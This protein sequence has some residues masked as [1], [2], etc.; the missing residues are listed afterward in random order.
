M[1]RNVGREMESGQPQGD[2]GA[3]DEADRGLSVPWWKVAVVLLLGGAV[4]TTLALKGNG[5]TSGQKDRDGNKA[6]TAAVAPGQAQ[7]RQKENDRGASETGDA[8][9]KVNG[10]PITRK[11]FQSMLQGLP[12][13]YR[14]GGTELKEKL[15]DTMIERE[16]LLQEADEQGIKK[17]RVRGG[18]TCCGPSPE[19]KRDTARIESLIQQE[20]LPDVE[21]TEEEVRT[22][23]RENKD[24]FGEDRGFEEIKSRLERKVRWRKEKE[25][26]DQYVSKLKNKATVERAE[27]PFGAKDKGSSPQNPLD[28]ALQKDVPV[29]ADFGR[30]KCTPC[31][32]MKP[33]LE[34]LKA[35]YEGRAE[36]LIIDTGDYPDLARRCDVRAIPTQIFYDAAGDEVDRHSG[37]MPREKL[38]EKLSE[39]GI[40]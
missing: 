8:L 25:T 36:V 7:E 21:V 4:A 23:Y 16:I 12:S 19:W 34:D 31:K 5:E 27:N 39:L 17:P 2:A 38:V 24:N 37:F 35:E 9:A 33:I 29:V 15:L 3:A 6:S 40:E 30:G 20:A 32:M 1:E 18:S 13:H 10:E 11:D 26:A 14:R 28:R 22:Y